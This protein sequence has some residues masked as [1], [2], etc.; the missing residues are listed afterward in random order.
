[1]NQIT[2]REHP[3]HVLAGEVDDAEHER[4][5]GD[6]MHDIGDMHEQRHD[7]RHVRRLIAH[8]RA[9]CKERVPGEPHNER[10]RLEEELD[11][12]DGAT[13]KAR[14]DLGPEE[15]VGQQTAASFAQRTDSSL[16]Q[17]QCRDAK[18]HDL[19]QRNDRQQLALNTLRIQQS[20]IEAQRIRHGACQQTP[21]A[22]QQIRQS[23]AVSL[24]ITKKLLLCR[25]L[26]YF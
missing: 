10:V 3:A 22:V 14:V 8:N 26:H 1:M 12:A 7:E 2:P 21:F 11:V 25:T 6:V 19:K 4:L 24:N 13:K 5:V 9:P 17:Q 18:R 20:K 16:E 23:I 15:V